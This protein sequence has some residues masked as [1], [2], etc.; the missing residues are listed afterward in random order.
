MGLKNT[1]LK[2]SLNNNLPS[3]YEE[4]MNE[5]CENRIVNVPHENLPTLLHFPLKVLNQRIDKE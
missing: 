1:H 2:S 5:L 4:D 3:N